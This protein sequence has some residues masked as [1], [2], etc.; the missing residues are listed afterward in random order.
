MFNKILIANRG[1]IAIRILCACRELGIAPVAIYSEADRHALHVQ[2]SDEA[3]CIGPARSQ[4]SY[5]NI[6]S[7]ISAA[8]IANVDAIHPGYGYLAESRDF[9]EVCGSCGIKFIG[10]S[11][12]NIELMGEK[13]RAR[14][15]MQ[16]EG[17]KIIPGTGLVTEE[18]EVQLSRVY[19]DIGFPLIIKAA[20]GGGGRGMRIVER[21]EKF[22]EA[23]DMARSEALEAFS[24]ADV[25]LER[26]LENPR[27]IE[28]Q[29]LADEKGNSIHL[30][31]RECSVQRRHQKLLEETPSPALDDETR[32]TL[33]RKIAEVMQKIRYSSA[34][35][36]EMLADSNGNFYFI[37]MNT[38]IQVEHPVTEMVT[39]VDLVKEQIRIAAGRELSIQQSEIEFRGHSIEC[40]INA[41]DP[42]TFRPSPGKITAYNPPGGPGIRVDSSAYQDWEVPR[43]YDSLIAKVI[44]YGR[45]REEAI[46]RMRRALSMF[47]VDGISTTIPLHLK[48]LSHSDF[49]AGNYGTSFLQNSGIIPGR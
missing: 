29:I 26:Y 49:V 32:D 40:R 25:Y 6:P 36:V 47:V 8:E 33:G 22:Q 27:H 31:E 39:G 37:E 16:Q 2:L 46:V 18:D 38:R 24:S 34:G 20:A 44:S 30:G 23:L 10:P 17:L 1:E 45:D 12:Q 15:R 4:E 13:A 5:L 43:H 9:A 3:V 42:E 19:Q 41:E 14:E 21:K 48:I 35:T 28:F 11:I 7:I